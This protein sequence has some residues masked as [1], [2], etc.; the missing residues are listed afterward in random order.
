M[1]S[2]ELLMDMTTSTAFQQQFNMRSTSD[3]DR[4][5]KSSKN[6][7]N[8]DVKLLDTL[9]SAKSCQPNSETFQI[10][11]ENKMRTGTIDGEDFW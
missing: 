1:I 4:K 6:K 2:S 10:H 5:K 7:K 8:P 3:Q 9:R 11:V